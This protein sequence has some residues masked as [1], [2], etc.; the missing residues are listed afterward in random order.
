LRSISTLRDSIDY[1][2]L[3]GT[4]LETPLWVPQ[5]IWVLGILF[6]SISSSI[7]FFYAVKAFFKDKHVFNKEF[8]PPSITQKVIKKDYD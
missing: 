3:S 4:P 5:L 7:V 2:S 1:K 8:G 6:F